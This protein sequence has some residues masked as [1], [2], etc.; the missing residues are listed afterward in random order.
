VQR[1][2]R[3]GDHEIMSDEMGWLMGIFGAQN[4]RAFERVD[5]S[6]EPQRQAPLQ[7]QRMQATATEPSQQPATQPRTHARTYC[8]EYVLVHTAPRLLVR[9]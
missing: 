3:L 7:M 8:I 5:R 9:C 1:P 6:E 4:G 2:N